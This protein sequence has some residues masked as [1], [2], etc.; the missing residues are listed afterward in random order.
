MI[1]PS[2]VFV[3]LTYHFCDSTAFSPPVIQRHLGHQVLEL[4][5]L[6]FELPQPLSFADLQPAV[7]R[8]PAFGDLQPCGPR[9]W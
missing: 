6:H 1:S 2:S 7:L 3:G 5:V 8:L 4:P 9:S